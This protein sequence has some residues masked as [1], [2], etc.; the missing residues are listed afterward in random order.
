M[1]RAHDKRI[2]NRLIPLLAPF[3]VEKYKFNHA[4]YW[5]V[6]LNEEAF[7]KIPGRAS[8]PAIALDTALSLKICISH[9]L[10]FLPTST[11]TRV[12]VG[13]KPMPFFV[14]RERE[15][16]GEEQ[17]WDKSNLRMKNALHILA[18]AF[19]PSS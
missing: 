4:N 12:A 1:S 13:P 16:V 8:K 11:S 10:Y 14:G 6:C 7:E 2:W 9:P 3:Q 19:D 17:N 15:G 5:T 18:P